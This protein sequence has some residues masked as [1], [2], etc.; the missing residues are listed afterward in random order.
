MS[1]QERKRAWVRD[2]GRIGF[3]FGGAEHILDRD[4]ARGIGLDLARASRTRGA[5]LGAPHFFNLNQ[6]CRQLSEAFGHCIYMVGSVMERADY[7][8]VD[9][10]CL[11]EDEDFSRLFPGAPGEANLHEASSAR[12]SLMNAAI[13]LYLH[14][15]TGLPID[16][17]FQQLTLANEKYPGLRNAMGIYME[18]PA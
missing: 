10:R 8:D 18:T 15:A 17:Q 14:R 5:Y 4:I 12:L 2:D 16:F 13:S 6:A 11:L 3:L 9:I 1:E 7:R